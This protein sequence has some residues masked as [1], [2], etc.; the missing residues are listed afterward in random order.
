MLVS[1]VYGTIYAAANNG[2]IYPV[3]L[4]S[5]LVLTQFSNVG[6]N[7]GRHRQSR[8]PASLYLHR[9]GAADHDF[10]GGVRFPHADRHLPD[11]P[12]VS[13]V[14]SYTGLPPDDMA[15]RIVTLYRRAVTTSVNH[16]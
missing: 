7:C 14:F 6:G 13:V 16:T 1:P 10:R 11:I 4:T 9:H 15:G 3:V 12:V 2:W 8:A 5:H